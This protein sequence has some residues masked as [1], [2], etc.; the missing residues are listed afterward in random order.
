MSKPKYANIKVFHRRDI[1]IFL[2][3]LLVSSSPSPANLLFQQGCIFFLSNPPGFIKMLTILQSFQ[4]QI[5][6]SFFYPSSCA[7]NWPQHLPLFLQLLNYFSQFPTLPAICP[8]ELH[9]APSAS[10]HSCLSTFH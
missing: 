1:L 10:S 7:L 4:L 8:D 9:T 6:L 5:Q 3:A 2:C